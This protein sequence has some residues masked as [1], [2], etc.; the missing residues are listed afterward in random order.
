MEHLSNH[1]FVHKD[2]AARNCLISSQRRIKVSS[3]SLSKD[4]YNSEYYHYRQAWIP[5]RWLPTESVFEDDYSTKSDVWAF[6]VLMWEV[7]SL[8]EMPHSKLSDDDVLEGLKMGKLKLPAPDGCPSKIYKLMVR[9][10]AP[11]LKE[12]PSFTDIVHALGDQPP[13]SKV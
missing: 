11:G 1:R 10:W 5:L 9:C 8:G 3:L 12:R 2:L 4:V 6:G 13:D 7:F